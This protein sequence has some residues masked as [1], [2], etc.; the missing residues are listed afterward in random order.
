MGS[1]GATND[2]QE[3]PPLFATI[4]AF[5]SRHSKKDFQLVSY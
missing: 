2:F 1:F 3:L 5:G 4:F